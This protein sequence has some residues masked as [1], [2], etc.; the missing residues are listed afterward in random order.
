M[1]SYLRSF[2]FYWQHAQHV[3]FDIIHVAAA[4]LKHAISTR[5]LIQKAGLLATPILRLIPK[6]SGRP[7][8]IIQRFYLV[9]II[10]WPNR[11]L[12]R[13]GLK[14]REGNGRVKTQF[15]KLGLPQRKILARDSGLTRTCA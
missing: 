14:R 6:A 8:K 2:V 12:I 7:A 1:L 11:E 13:S 10:A 15:G 9:E 3:S 4:R 5:V